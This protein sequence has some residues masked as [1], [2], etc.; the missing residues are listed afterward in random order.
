MAVYIGEAVLILNGNFITVYIFWNIRKRLK[1]TSYLL[2][3]LAVSDI[4]VG[5]AI[6]LALYEGIAVMMKTDPSAIVVKTAMCM[7]TL[8]LT[9]SISSLALISLER[10]I[11]ILWPFRHRMLNTWYYYIS[12]GIV[13]CVATLNAYVTLQFNLYNAQSHS[14]FRFLMA[15]TVITS[16]LVITVAY[17]A[18]YIS[19][20]RNSLPGNHS[21]TMAQNRNLAKTLFIVTALSII[22][23]LPNGIYFCFED[24]LQNLYTFGVQITIAIQY[25]NSFLNPVVY[26]FKIPDFKKLLKKLFCRY[27]RQRFSFNENASTISREISLIAVK[28]IEV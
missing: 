12:V 13:W 28:A 23:Y 3:N 26:S 5:T 22:T 11:A 21:R 8:G 19:I 20:R 4:I 18:I 17:L 24:Y 6:S 9:S 7:D 1:R 14:A 16:V 15:F 2:I 25:S 10:M 27:P